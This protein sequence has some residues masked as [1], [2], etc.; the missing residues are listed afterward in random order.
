MSRAVWRAVVNLSLNGHSH[1]SCTRQRSHRGVSHVQELPLEPL[2]CDESFEATEATYSLHMAPP[3]LD[4]ESLRD[5]A[6]KRP[7]HDAHIWQMNHAER[8]GWMGI[9][10]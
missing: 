5:V 1:C 8:L 6:D 7:P 3:E 10:V 2:E 9:G 4:S